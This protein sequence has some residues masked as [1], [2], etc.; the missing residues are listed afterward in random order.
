VVVVVV[1]GVLERVVG[2]GEIVG[3]FLRRRRHRCLEFLWFQFFFLDVLEKVA[4]SV[5][6]V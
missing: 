6:P 2:A 1:G 5:W 3:T 4:G